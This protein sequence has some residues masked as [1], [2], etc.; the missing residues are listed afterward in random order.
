MV[1][2]LQELTAQREG[3]E[4][5]RENKQKIIGKCS[6]PYNR[7]SLGA[8]DTQDQSL[9]VWEPSPLQEVIVTETKKE[10]KQGKRR[11]RGK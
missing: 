4:R 5:G 1:P 11:Q 8:L 2:A 3:E 7:I 10:G 9:E 6:N